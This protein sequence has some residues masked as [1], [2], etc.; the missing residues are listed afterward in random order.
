MPKHKVPIPS[1]ESQRVVVSI[2]SPVVYILVLF[3][4]NFST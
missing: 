4:N 3:L 1:I 2:L